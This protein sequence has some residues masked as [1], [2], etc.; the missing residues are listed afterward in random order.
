MTYRTRL[1]FQISSSF[2]ESCLNGRNLY[3]FDITFSGAIFTASLVIENNRFLII[4]SQSN[5]VCRSTITRVAKCDVFGK[6]LFYICMTRT[7][8]PYR[9]FFTCASGRILNCFFTDIINVVS[10]LLA[11]SVTV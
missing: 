6:L 11:K 4:T 1:I 9:H 10:G 5:T 8:H 7:V 2:Q 3:I